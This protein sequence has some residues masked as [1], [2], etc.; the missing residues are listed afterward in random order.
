M[1]SNPIQNT[2]DAKKLITN[3]IRERLDNP[4]KLKEIGHYGYDIYLPYLYYQYLIR[5]GNRPNSSEQ[6]NQLFT[7]SSSFFYDAAWELCRRGILRPGVTQNQKQAT[8]DGTGGNGYSLTPF[9]R[10]WLKESHLDDFVP[11]E[12]ERFGKMLEPYRES[13]G[14]AFYQRA[15]EAIRCYGAHAYLATCVMCGAAAESI[16]L[17]IA[18]LSKSEDE[19]MKIYKTRGGFNKLIKLVSNGLSEYR[20]KELE[21]FIT[22]T[23]Y[24]RNESAHGRSSEIADNEAYTSLAIML[25]LA[26]FAKD[27]WDSWAR[28]P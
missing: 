23:K 17:E 2:E 20:Q 25:R 28:Q 16:I 6:S 12:P 27:N 8:E 7:I 24:W 26:F 10:T 4:S 11:T 5:D 18:H 3:I 21:G 15:Q 1:S 22:L 14:S 19:I 9:G 13:L